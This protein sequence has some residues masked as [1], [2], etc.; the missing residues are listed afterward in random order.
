M[1]CETEVENVSEDKMR[2]RK[3]GRDRERGREEGEG[4]EG[5]VDTVLLLCICF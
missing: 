4:R 5:A 1:L 3:W 2:V